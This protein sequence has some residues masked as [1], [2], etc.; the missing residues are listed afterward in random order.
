MQQAEFGSFFQ[1]LG[2]RGIFKNLQGANVAAW[3]DFNSNTK[4]CDGYRRLVAERH[5][6]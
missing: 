5:S 6:R 1:C 3:F 2:I 4:V